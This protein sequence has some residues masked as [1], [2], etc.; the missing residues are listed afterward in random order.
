MGTGMS[1]VQITVLHH[2]R[3]G[4]DMPMKHH[5][6][7]SERAWPGGGTVPILVLGIGQ[8]TIE[9][10]PADPEHIDELGVRLQTLAGKLKSMEQER[11]KDLQRS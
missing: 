1:V 8:D 7:L 5:A 2:D 10:W 11:Q 4:P 6:W 3:G 9:I